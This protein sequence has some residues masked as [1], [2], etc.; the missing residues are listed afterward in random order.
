LDEK[1][2]GLN[3]ALDLFLGGIGVGTFLTAVIVSSFSGYKFKKVS[4]IAAYLTPL[5]VGAGFLFLILHLG[6]PFRLY[7][8]FTHFN[9]TSPLSWG[10]W[11]Q[12]IFFFISVL[13]AL[14][15]LADTDQFKKLPRLFDNVKRK[16]IIGFIG[17]PFALGVGIYHGFLLMVFKSRPLWNT[18]PTVI[19][20]ICGFIMTGIALVVLVLSFSRHSKELLQEL[21]LSRNI[22]GAAIITQLIVIALWLSSL[23]FGPGSSHQ[24]ML[25]LIT[26]YGLP[27]WGGAIFLGLVLPLLIGTYAVFHKGK[28]EAFSYSVPKITSLMVLTG[29]FI[30]RYVIIVAAQ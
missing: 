3:I 2:W 22:L 6:R 7:R 27:F 5:M 21:T 29:G 1:F 15:W 23:Y 8:M 12:A 13:Y 20:A 9:V 19:M 26:E 16:R 10:G 17:F 18:G 24:S 14:M 28:K 11:L 25:R 30:L 4:S